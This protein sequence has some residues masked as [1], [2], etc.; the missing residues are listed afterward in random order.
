MILAQLA[1]VLIKVQLNLLILCIWVE[2]GFYLDLDKVSLL[3]LRLIF[4]EV[5]FL[6]LLDGVSIAADVTVYLLEVAISKSEKILTNDS[7]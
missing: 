6:N 2:G 7:L 3:S 5:E 4:G 1:L